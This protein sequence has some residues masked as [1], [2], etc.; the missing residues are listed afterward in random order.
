[1]HA[2]RIRLIELNNLHNI[3]Y[4]TPQSKILATPTMVGNTD[5][6]P[7]VHHF[8]VGKKDGT[9]GQTDKPYGHEVSRRRSG[10]ATA[11]ISL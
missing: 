6:T 4:R 11:V 8:N 5:Y 2:L 3:V 9:N 7:C 10:T 1:M